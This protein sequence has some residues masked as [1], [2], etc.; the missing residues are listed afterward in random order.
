LSI[1]DLFPDPVAEVLKNAGAWGSEHAPAD[2]IVIF[3]GENIGDGS[4]FEWTMFTSGGD[5]C[6]L[7]G[8]LGLAHGELFTLYAPGD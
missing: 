6:R 8:L 5:L 2:V 4:G 7:L 1:H 3:R